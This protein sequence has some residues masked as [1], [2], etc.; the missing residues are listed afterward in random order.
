MLGHITDTLCASAVR[1]KK[2]NDREVMT[3]YFKNVK[4][5]A[6]HIELSHGKGVLY[7]SNKWH[8]GEHL[9]PYSS[10]LDNC[11]QSHKYENLEMLASYAR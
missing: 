2:E 7:S 4:T 1:K 9:N 11:I 6:V 5:Y 10:D 3:T 8:L